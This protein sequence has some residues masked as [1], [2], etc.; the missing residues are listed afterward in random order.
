MKCNVCGQNCQAEQCQQDELSIA[1]EISLSRRKKVKGKCCTIRN[2]KEE[3]VED[4]L[5]QRVRQ[6]ADDAGLGD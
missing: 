3:K 5:V 1:K 6:M 4:K 2:S